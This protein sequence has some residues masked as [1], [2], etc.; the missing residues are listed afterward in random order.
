LIGVEEVPE[1]GVCGRR[2]AVLERPYG[3]LIRV[4]AV[5]DRIVHPGFPRGFAVSHPLMLERVP[6]DWPRS[7]ASIAIDSS[8]MT[9]QRGKHR[10]GKSLSNT[11]RGVDPPVRSPTEV[12]S[13]TVATTHSHL[14]A[15]VTP[16]AHKKVRP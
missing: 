6:G 11:C 5:V 14:S 8:P 3:Q 4:D 1:L 13:F 2:R 12:A 16:P 15:T 7:V 9:A 10:T